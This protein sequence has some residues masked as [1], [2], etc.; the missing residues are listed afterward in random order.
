MAC[1][2]QSVGP[3][4]PQL[5]TVQTKQATVDL[6]VLVFQG[7]HTTTSPANP[8]GTHPQRSLTSWAEEPRRAH[9]CFLYCDMVAN[10]ELTVNSVG[11][12]SA[13]LGAC[14]SPSQTSLQFPGPCWPPRALLPVLSVPSCP[15][16][17]SVLLAGLFSPRSH[18]LCDSGKLHNLSV[19]CC[20]SCKKRGPSP[21]AFGSLW[22]P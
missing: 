18:T 6:E 7:L 5:P 21:G 9:S 12:A 15:W 10:S 11:W 14:E 19:W 3:N 20:P 13:S 17:S 4:S 8:R 2:Q 16:L 22:S 1:P